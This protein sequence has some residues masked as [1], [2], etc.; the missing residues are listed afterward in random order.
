[1]K[2]LIVANGDFFSS[3]GGG[4]VYVKNLVDE[5][6]D[7]GLDIAIIS[8][9]TEPSYKDNIAKKQYRNVDL[10]E[11]SQLDEVSIVEIVKNISPNMFFL[12]AHK[13]Y[14]SRIASMLSIP[15]VITAHHGGITCPVGTLLN[16]RDEICKVKVSQ[17]GCLKC[18]L[19][20]IK[21]GSLIYPIFKKLPL[22]FRLKLGYILSKLPFIYFVSPIGQASL[23]IDNKQK[24]WSEI[25]KNVDLMIAPSY[26]IANNMVLNGLNEHKIKVLHHGVPFKYHEIEKKTAIVKDGCIRFFYVGRI[27]YVKGIHI[28]LEAFNMLNLESCELH[29]IGSIDKKYKK[30]IL[31][32]YKSNSRVFFYGKIEPSKV[33]EYI[34][35]FDVLIHPTICLEAF[36]LNIS[37]ALLES[38]P[39]IATRCGGAEMQIR[40]KENGLL[41]A[42]NDVYALAQAMK[43]MI[44]NPLEVKRMSINAPKKVVS[45]RE[46]VASIV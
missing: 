11:V 14:F 18:V 8:F 20:N 7:Q 37:E 40:D 31:H 29:L 21:G 33:S 12:H 25:I 26:A 41:I 2:I 24:E 39:V 13:A 28:L 6:I 38:K 27:C 43:W 45:M 44:D 42:P 30:K 10:F 17:K 4:Q 15:C 23:S 22:S 16:H 1:M 46:N 3:Y 5:M 19:K 34:S 32:K 35:S 36:G 9:I